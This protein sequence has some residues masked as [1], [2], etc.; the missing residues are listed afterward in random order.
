MWGILSTVLQKRFPYLFVDI[1]SNSKLNDDTKV[2]GFFII[3]II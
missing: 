1:Q 2:Q 3:I